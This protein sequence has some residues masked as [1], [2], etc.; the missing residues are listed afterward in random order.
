MITDG[1]VKMLAFSVA[2]A[3]FSTVA[4]A[5]ST[6]TTRAAPK[7]TGPKCPGGTVQGKCVNAALAGLSIHRSILMNNGNMLIAPTL[8][9]QDWVDVDPALQSA[10]RQRYLSVGSRSARPFNIWGH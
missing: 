6:P 5:Q 7:L 8:P 1:F 9:S 10:R 3:A 4:S 2:F